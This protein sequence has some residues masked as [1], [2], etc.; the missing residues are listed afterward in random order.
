MYCVDRK[1]NTTLILKRRE[2]GS[3]IL[4]QALEKRPAQTW[5][6][7]WLVQPTRNSSRLM[8][9]LDT[10]GQTHTNPKRTVLSDGPNSQLSQREQSSVARVCTWLGCTNKM[11]VF[12]LLFCFEVTRKCWILQ[13]SAIS[14]TFDMW[15]VT[16]LIS[17]VK[18]ESGWYFAYDGWVCFF[19][20]ATLIDFDKLLFHTSKLI[21]FGSTR[22]LHL[23]A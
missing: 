7:Y 13:R 8:L 16:Y 3:R 11:N 19:Y 20:F 4:E 17:I 6:P 22:A 10:A 21:Q 12:F 18:R 9:N 23:E 15:R 5:V 14:S 1:K 2:W